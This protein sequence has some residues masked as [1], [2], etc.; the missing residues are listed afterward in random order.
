MKPIHDQIK[1]DLKQLGIREGGVLLVHSSLRS[2]GKFP[3]KAAIVTSALS[4]VLGEKGTLLMP[5]L[6][7]EI[8]T[9]DNPIFDHAKTPSN[10]GYL[11]EYF[12]NQP[13]VLRS[14]HPTH[15]VSGKGVLAKQILSENFKDTTPCGQHS[16]FVK[17]REANGQIL[18]L[19]CGLRPNTS[20]H[21]IEELVV[22]EYLYSEEVLFEV[23]LANGELTKMKV[24]SHDFEGWV[25]RYDRISLIMSSPELKKG[26]ILEAESFLVDTVP[27]WEKAHGMLKKNPLYFIDRKKVEG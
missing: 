23:K 21:A 22:P 15:S 1:D 2:L 8:V 27:M 9:K 3:D 19:G 20:M 11:T 26:K 17:L 16:P 13:G 12:R 5:A 25:Q 14:V 6:S 18:F 10:V 4:E 7:Y 24:L